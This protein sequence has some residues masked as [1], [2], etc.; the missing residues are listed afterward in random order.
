V[1]VP[2]FTAVTDALR[3]ADLV[4]AF[5]RAEYGV[6]VV[7]RCVDLADLL[8]AA[9]SGTARAVILSAD[10]RR[11]DRD[12]LADEHLQ[13][14]RCASECVSFGHRPRVRRDQARRPVRNGPPVWSDQGDRTRAEV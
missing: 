13:P 5:E 10:M 7:R 12:A 2:V 11:L 8:S 6:S 4:S 14:P 1:T 3:E 9:T